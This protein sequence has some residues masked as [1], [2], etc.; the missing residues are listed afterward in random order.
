MAFREK[1]IDALAATE[2][3][4]IDVTLLVALSI[5]AEP[6]GKQGSGGDPM[7]SLQEA[8][9]LFCFTLA[10]GWLSLGPSRVVAAAGWTRSHGHRLTLL[11]MAKPV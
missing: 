1:N 11:F 4:L 9:S 8:L 10:A 7:C 6:L 5:K 2:P 3:S